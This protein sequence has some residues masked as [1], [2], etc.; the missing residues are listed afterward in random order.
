MRLALLDGSLWWSLPLLDVLSLD[1]GKAAA[2]SLADT[3]ELE[4]VIVP[5]PLPL[6]LLL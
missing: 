2:S 3:E 6:L 4:V 1:A 5:P